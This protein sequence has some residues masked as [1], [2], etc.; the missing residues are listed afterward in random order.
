M[1]L[2]PCP[3]CGKNEIAPPHLRS[4]KKKHFDNLHFTVFCLNCGCCP[5]YCVSTEKEAIEV[6]NTRHT[7]KEEEPYTNDSCCD[8]K[9]ADW[10]L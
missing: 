4:E 3:F 2:L 6:W 8:G 10:S 1:E 5:D 7:F 9:I